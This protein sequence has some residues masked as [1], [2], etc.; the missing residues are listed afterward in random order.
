DYDPAWC[1]EL[2]EQREI[3]EAN[4]KGLSLVPA[5]EF[6]W[7]RVRRSSRGQKVLADNAD[8][9]KRVLERIR[10]EGPLSSLD[11]ERET[12][13]TKDW[14]GMPENAVRA[15]L[16]AYTVTGVIGLAWRGGNRRYYDLLD[17]LLPAE[18]LAQEVPE[19][20]QLRDRKSTR[21]N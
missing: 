8:V 21:L 15:V 20:E 2:Y 12:G 10:T 18:L 13:P 19:R 1:D 3:F 14:F 5:S 6:A 16:E 9:A 17:R 7:F 11:F 4:N